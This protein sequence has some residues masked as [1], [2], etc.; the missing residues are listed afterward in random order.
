VEGFADDDGVLMGVVAERTPAA[1]RG[2]RA[3]P[4]APSRAK[5]G[6]VPAA[7]ALVLALALPPATPATP[8][9]DGGIAPTGAARDGD[10]LRLGPEGAPHSIDAFLDPASS[11]SWR[12]WLEL[13][14]LVADHDGELEVRLHWAG[15]GGPRQPQIE[16]VR[17]FVVSLAYRG[18]TEAALRAVARDG[19]ERLHAR[20][21]DPGSHE[22]LAHELSVPLSTIGAALRDRCA[23][24]RVEEHGR[25]L[26]EA[27]ALEP[28]AMMRLPA[29]VVSEVA[30]DDGPGLERLRP[31]LGL[32][33]V[34]RRSR[35]DPG[36][37]GPPPA[38]E[39]TS[40]RMQRP[41]L[42]GLLLGGPGL[43]HRFVVMARDEED[44]TLFVVLPSVLAL[45]RDRPGRVAVHVVSRGVSDGAERLRHR[46]CAARVLG[47][48]A[49]YLDYLARDALLR[50]APGPGDTHLL[51][52]LDDVPASRCAD[53][54]DPVDLDLP[55]GAW[56]DGLP[57]S[58]SELSTL[59]ATLRLLDAA[60][61]PLDQLLISPR[62]DL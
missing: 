28:D 50:Q 48:G 38:V 26:H 57:R 12:T 8:A 41:P 31:E 11:L 14:R 29:F 20:L 21:V 55:D 24:Q 2:K 56:L 5:L 46:L 47:L 32:E 39:A 52:A 53:E 17:A 35:E 34:R 25:R 23:R 49:A 10:V 13:R 60:R 61:R 15:S 9:C 36:P 19:L 6:A 33:G 51:E 22:A 44:P 4:G 30:F 18:R 1:A 54:V 43:P 37:V 7:A 16:R 3:C 62:E 42:R 59:D 58:R 27:F 40:E 45:R